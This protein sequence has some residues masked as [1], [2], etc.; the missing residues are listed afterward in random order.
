MLAND[1]NLVDW[2]QFFRVT[3]KMAHI[4]DGINTCYDNSKPRT[5]ALHVEQVQ[6]FGFSG[7]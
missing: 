3:R 6:Q 2:P 4:F 1:R 7:R 5:S